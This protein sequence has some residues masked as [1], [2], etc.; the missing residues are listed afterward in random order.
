M[1][2]MAIKKLGEEL[3]H[4]GPEL[5]NFVDR[6]VQLYEEQQ[7][8]ERERQKEEREE[9]LKNR[10][11]DVREKELEQK[12]KAEKEQREHE[13]KIKQLELQMNGKKEESKNEETRKGSVNS[14]TRVPKLPNFNPDLDDLPAYI[15]RFETTATQNKWSEEEKFIGLSNLLTGVFAN[16]P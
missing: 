1:D 9:R 8:R 10:E 7:N 6:Q 12:T 5:R 15:S 11:L 14:F 16:T 2:L 3:G 4:E 13:L